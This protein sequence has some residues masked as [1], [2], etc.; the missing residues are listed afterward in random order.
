MLVRAQ[1]KVVSYSVSSM[2]AANVIGGQ[3]IVSTIGKSHVDSA[4]AALLFLLSLKVTKAYSLWKHCT[5]H[6]DQPMS[7][8]NLEQ[9]PQRLVRKYTSIDCPKC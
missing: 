4:E 3:K 1:Q 9:Q 7:A 8:V 6:C 5:Q 2:G